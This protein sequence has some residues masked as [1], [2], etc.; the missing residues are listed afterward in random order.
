MN[1]A[2]TF[3]GAPM[4]LPLLSTILIRGVVPGVLVSLLA[5]PPSLFSQAAAE[6]HLVSPQA[7]QQQV[8]IASAT[9][10]QNIATVT[11]FL[12]SPAAERAMRDAHMDPVQVRTAIPT[13]SNQ[14]LQ[15]LAARA[16][17]TQQKFAAGMIS[18]DMLLL[19]ILL[20]AVI[21]IVAAVH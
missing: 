15:N 17:V 18:N 13:I 8:E 12:S 3:F 4:R 5:C 6:D 10:Q 11:G 20:V 2:N 7:L 21:I 14:E 1:A 9:R 16:S 19:V